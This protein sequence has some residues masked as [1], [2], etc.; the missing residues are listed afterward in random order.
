MSFYDTLLIDPYDPSQKSENGLDSITGRRPKE[1][2]N[3]GMKRKRPTKEEILKTMN[4]V[5]KPEFFG[6][7]A[8]T[9]DQQDSSEEAAEIDSEGITK[10]RRGRQ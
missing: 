6:T 4:G 2:S 8:L 10:R 5:P 3:R 9:K 7:L 1:S